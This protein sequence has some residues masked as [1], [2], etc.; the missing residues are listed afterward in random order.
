VKSIQVFIF[1]ILTSYGFGQVPTKC[2]VYQQVG[3][4]GVFKKVLKIE[5]NQSGKPIYEEYKGYL[6]FY[7]GGPEDNITKYYYS[8]SLLTLETYIL[9]DYNYVD[10]TEYNDSTKWL[11]FYND[12][13]QLVREEIWQRE[14]ESR[15]NFKEPDW[16]LWKEIFYE[17]DSLG[18]L[19]LYDATRNNWSF[20]DKFTWEYDNENRC[21]EYKRYSSSKK[22]DKLTWREIYVYNEDGYTINTRSYHEDGDSIHV[23]FWDRHYTTNDFGQIIEEKEIHGKEMWE[24]LRYFYDRNGRIRKTIW[25]G[26]KGDL[27]VTHI[28]KYKY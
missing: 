20:E 7:E 8:D 2:D 21:K 9:E 23:E 14:Y 17:Y 12:N 13:D 6:D 3:S 25:K 18:N 10:G 16:K 28:Y 19:I 27:K 5:Y 26:T 1:I 24:W 15:N 22:R 4:F 11:Y